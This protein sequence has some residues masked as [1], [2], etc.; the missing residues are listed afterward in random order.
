MTPASNLLGKGAY[1]YSRKM[2]L[3]MEFFSDEQ[4]CQKQKKNQTT[5]A[6]F[7]FYFMEKYTP[8]LANKRHLLQQ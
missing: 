7:I 1:F 6:N 5:K 4:G 8:S 3:E 2:T